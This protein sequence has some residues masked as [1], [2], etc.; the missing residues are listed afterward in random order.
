MTLILSTTGC[1]NRRELDTLAIV[2]GIAF[3]KT[4]NPGELQLTAQ[5]VKPAELK[6]PS[7]TGGG[8]AGRAYLNIK[9][10]G[11]TVF[12]TVRGFTHKFNQKL[13]FQHNQVLIFS[14]DIA[15]QGVQK[16]IDFFLRE[17]EAR[18]TVWVL[19]A[20]DK[21]SEILDVTPQ[22][23]KLPAM[24]I[25][26]EIES[27]AA[28]S[29]SPQVK[30]EQFVT[31]LMSKT[32]APVAPLIEV[33]GEGNEKTALISGAAVFKKDKLA[34][35][36][37]TTETRGLLW[38]LGEVKSGII[39]VDCPGGDGKVSME[40]LRASSKVTPEIKD[41][42]I[43]IKVKIKEEGNVGS[44]SCTENF[45]LPP[46][47]EALEKKKAAA[48]QTEVQAALK[49]ARQLNTDIFGFG[50][51]VHQRYP[52]LWNEYETR[53]DEVFPNIEVTVAVEAKLRRI[54]RITKPVYPEK[55]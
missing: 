29:Q 11:E 7:R 16:Y 43:G 2:M 12:E 37:D 8:A 25:T 21:A 48:I 40:I 45:L 32:T 9:N 41:G 26:D 10:T 53:W 42:K 4:K 24:D 20:K 14:R 44:Q 23:R 38:V 35:Q 47:I 27:Q 31:R 15:K 36:L 51:L 55:E 18:L 28:T 22:L 5:I 34:G 13:Y 1:W 46:A 6:A 17:P 54:G 3:D 50:D 33:S 30:L 19:V 39:D 49:K 52:R